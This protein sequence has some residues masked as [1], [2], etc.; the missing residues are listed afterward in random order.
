ML[1]ILPSSNRHTSY[2]YSLQLSERRRLVR[3]K[4]P[5][6]NMFAAAVLRQGLHLLRRQ[7]DLSGRPVHLRT[8]LHHLRHLKELRHANRGPGRCRRRGSSAFLRRYDDRGVLRTA[9]EKSHIY[10]G[11]VQHVRYI[12][13]HRTYSGRGADGSSVMEM[14]LLD[15]RINAETARIEPDNL[16]IVTC[17]LEALQ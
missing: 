17:R 7:M 8:R 12:L 2:H 10:C 3:L 14:V 15:V 6:H 5:P 9:K 13:G 1:T 16:G 4:L 11:A